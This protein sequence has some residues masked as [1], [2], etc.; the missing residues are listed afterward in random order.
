MD[1]KIE[2]SQEEI[3]NSSANQL[4][5]S[6]SQNVGEK[7]SQSENKVEKT[8]EEKQD[9]ATKAAQQKLDEVEQSVSKQNSKKSKIMNLVFFFVNIAVVAGILVYQL[10][11]EEFVSLTGYRFNF[12]YFFIMIVL[13]A[14]VVFFESFAISYLLKQ[15]TGKWRPALSFKVSQVGKYYDSVTPMATGGQPFQVTYLKNRGVSLHNAL[16]IPLAKYMFNQIG[17]LIIC[18]MALIVS[19]VDKSYGT[20]V[21]ITS[22][23]GFVLSFFVLF[24][25][26]FL[27]ISKKLGRVLVAK[28]LKLLQ[29][30]KIVKNYEKQYEKITKSIGDYQDVMK[31]YASSPKDFIIMVFVSLFKLFAN[32]SIPFFIVKFFVPSTGADMYFKLLVMGVLVDLSASFFPLPGGTGMNELSFTAAFG[33]VVAGQAPLVWVLLLWRFCSYYFYLV[34]GIFILSYDMAIGNRRYRWQ[35]VRNNL[36]EESAVFKQQQINRFRADRAKR[37][38]LKNKT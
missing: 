4:T 34:Q 16:S 24:L 36:A 18:L 26:F 17:W 6:S 20:F 38:K 30:I 21:S 5:N 35:V 13:L 22:V 12:L 33:A 31:Q 25:M 29:K 14:G 9:E 8:E 3:E 32:Y 10:T 2:K 11:N 7:F 37:R 27:S 15:S 19:N 28:T 23:I 1:E